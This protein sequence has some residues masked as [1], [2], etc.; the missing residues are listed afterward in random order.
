MA[1]CGTYAGYNKHVY[2]KQPVCE[3]CRSSYRAYKKEYYNK[4]KTR[5]HSD[6]KKWEIKNPEKVKA[7]KKKWRKSNPDVIRL[8]SRKRRVLRLNSGFEKYTEMDVLNKYGTI[9][10]ICN[11]TID[12]LAPRKVGVLNWEKGLHI[13]HVLPIIKGGSDTLDNVRPSHGLCNISK[14]ATILERKTME[15]NF[16]AEIDPSLFEEDFDNIELED[17]D[18]LEFEDDDDEEDE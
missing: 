17:L 15:E 11:L 2:Y 16:E 5:V 18:D 6:N 8:H 4:N 12:M 7:I 14:G 10:H 3:P 13:D 9:C 1:I